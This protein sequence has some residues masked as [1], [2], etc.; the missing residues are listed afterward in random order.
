MRHGG[1]AL[2]AAEDTDYVAPAEC[3][4]LHAEAATFG[5]FLETATP[6]VIALPPG[7]PYDAPT[8]RAALRAPVMIAA[9]VSPAA[10]GALP[11]WLAALPPRL[12][13]GDPGLALPRAGGGSACRRA[14]R[15]RQADPAGRDGRV[16]GEQPD[17]QARSS[18]IAPGSCRRRR[19]FAIAFS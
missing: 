12:R 4:M 11:R 7:H 14:W 1:T 3:V 9:T 10:E 18:L 19:R 8:V 5:T 16:G 17:A 6:N 13:V 2:V 15:R